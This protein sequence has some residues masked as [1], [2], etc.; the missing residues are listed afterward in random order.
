[1]RCRFADALYLNWNP[2]LFAHRCTMHDFWPLARGPK[3]DAINREFSPQA[4]PR[5][6]RPAP[7]RPPARPPARLLPYRV[8]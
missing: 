3:V 2:E 6:A 5:F 7:P 8:A 4:R 1:M